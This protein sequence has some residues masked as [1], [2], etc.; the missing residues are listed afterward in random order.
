MSQPPSAFLYACRPLTRPPAHPS[1]RM[2]LDLKRVLLI[3]LALTAVYFIVILVRAVSSWRDV[4]PTPIDIG[5]GLVTDFFDTLGIGSFATTT[6]LFRTTK[7]VKDDVIPGT[8]NVAHT[9]AIITQA[10]IYTQLVTVD[11]LTLIGM[12][13]AAVAGAW[14]GA[15]IV[16][17][18]PTRWIQFGMGLCMLA[19]ALLTASQALNI[20]PGGGETIGVT[21]TRLVIALVGNFALGALMTIG[22][23]LYAPCMVLVSMLGMNPVAAFPIMMGS[24]AFLMPVASARFLKHGKVDLRAVMGIIIGGVP[25]VLVAALIVKSLPLTALRWLVVLVVT[26]TAFMLLM[27]ARKGRE[28]EEY[29]AAV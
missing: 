29:E 13:L 26:Y 7:A 20:L 17:R 8:L 21:G 23:G 27:S 19:A 22:I 5:I 28:P 1:T 6:F 4:K 12:I 18:W 3:A 25:A 9:L 14:L 10:F 2:A 15:G 24:C 16:S 11:P